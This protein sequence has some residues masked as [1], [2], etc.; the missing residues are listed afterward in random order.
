MF[1]FFHKPKTPEKYDDV[2]WHEDAPDGKAVHIALMFI[3]LASRDHVINDGDLQRLNDALK[4]RSKTPSEV[5]D[6]H[7]D[8][9]ILS[10]MVDSL[11]VNFL[12]EFYETTF[13]KTIESNDEVALDRTDNQVPYDIDDTWKNVD[14]TVAWLDQQYKAWLSSKES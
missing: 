9:K 4:E 13:L 7:A 6:E 2:D 1:S 14:K 8:G 10:S 11:A 12:N 3:W 5:L